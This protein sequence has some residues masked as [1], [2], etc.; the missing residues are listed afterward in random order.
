MKK[1][2][3]FATVVYFIFTFGIGIVFALTLPGYFATFTIP[4]EVITE[5]LQNSDFV[6][7]IVLTEPIVFPVVLARIVCMIGVGGFGTVCGVGI[8]GF[9]A[10]HR[11]YEAHENCREQDGEKSFERMP[12]GCLPMLA[13][14]CI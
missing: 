2:K 6:T 9:T 10:R 1:G 14:P 12:H 3:I 5:A 13:R 11:K 7:G 4:A 8:F